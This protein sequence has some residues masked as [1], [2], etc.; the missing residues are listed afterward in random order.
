MIR[1][2][3]ET[4]STNADLIAL[5]ASGAE[6]GL[7]LRA[8]RQTAGK[9]RQG[10]AWQSP[11][12]NLYASTIVRLRPADPPA[13]TLA[14]AAA[15]ALEEAVAAFLPGLVQL[16]WPN[17]LLIGGAKLSGILLERAGDAVVI[18]F[19]VNLAHHP[20]DLDRTATSLAAHG[21]APDPQAF[22]ETLADAMARWIARWRG[23]GLG[24]VRERWLARAHPPGTALTARQADGTV[25]DGLFAGLDRDGA[26][27]LRLADGTS[28]VIHAADVFLL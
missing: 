6:E 17:D 16:K 20:E 4:G 26:L 5:A 12:G 21:A 2:L 23:E 25:L 19:G 22:A 11:P 28:R 18:G 24:P 9:G 8:D 10:R 1:T 7:W 13:A 14:L 27:I 15:V 3:P